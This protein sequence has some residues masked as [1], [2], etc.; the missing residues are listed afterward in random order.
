MER[1][2]L[3]IVQLRKRGGTETWRRGRALPAGLQPLRV[4]LPFDRYVMGHHPP[5]II[6]SLSRAVFRRWHHFEERKSAT[7]HAVAA[8]VEA[9]NARRYVDPLVEAGVVVE[10]T[11]R[12]RNRAWRAPEILNALGAFGERAGRRTLPSSPQPPS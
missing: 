5:S 7:R 4:D 2:P 12:T 10:S 6:Y 1:P 11:H 8:P 3:G 9:G